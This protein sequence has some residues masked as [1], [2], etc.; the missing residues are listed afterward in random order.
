M[1]IIRHSSLFVLLR[2]I[3]NKLARRPASGPT[4]HNFQSGLRINNYQCACVHAQRRPGREDA[5][6]PYDLL[7]RAARSPCTTDIK[8]IL[9][10]YNSLEIRCKNRK[11]SSNAGC[12]L[13]AG[14]IMRTNKSLL[15]LEPVSKP[16]N[17]EMTSKSGPVNEPGT[18][19][20]YFIRGMKLSSDQWED[21]FRF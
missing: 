9:Q 21:S 19:E 3:N 11:P 12:D 4:E 8:H 16:L 13:R 15:G 10:R 1:K 17:S 6:Q 20:E 18:C 7:G 14:S 5:C 2:R